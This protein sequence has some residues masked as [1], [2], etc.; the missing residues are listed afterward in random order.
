VY[1][2]V[3]EKGDASVLKMLKIERDIIEAESR[4]QNTLDPLT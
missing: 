3:N 2:T 4:G 1:K